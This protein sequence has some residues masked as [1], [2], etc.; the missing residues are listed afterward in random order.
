MIAKGATEISKVCLGSDELNKVCLG[1]T[2]LWSAAQPLPYDA[3]VEYIEN[4]ANQRVNLGISGYVKFKITS[5]VNEITSNTQVLVSSNASG[6]AG[7]WFGATPSSGNGYWGASTAA[8][9]HVD[10]VAT[11]KA[12]IEVEFGSSAVSGT[13]NGEAFTRS[14]SGVPGDWWLFSTVTGGYSFIGKIKA[15]QAYQNDN[16]VLDLIAVRIG[17]DGY[18]YNRLNGS[19]LTATNESTFIAGNDVTP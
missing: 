15:L 7:S 9:A 4:K 17:T 6:A 3:Q 13:V 16:L 11:T 18:L 12:N 2:E 14:R 8:G 5:Q 10:I 19:F 1:A